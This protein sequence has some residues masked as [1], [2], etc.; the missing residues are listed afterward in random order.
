MFNNAPYPK[1][2]QG[3]ITWFWL[4]NQNSHMQFAT[5]PKLRGSTLNEDQV[6]K[7]RPPNP[8]KN[9]TNPRRQKCAWN[10]QQ[11]RGRAALVRQRPCP[12]CRVALTQRRTESSLARLLHH[13]SCRPQM[14]S[15][16]W[17]M[18]TATRCT[19][20]NNHLIWDAEKWYTTD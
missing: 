5:R 13:S 16:S 15:T 10:S 6:G 14:H 1:Y 7:E 11:H 17:L 4:S 19:K 18:E 20:N 9:P 2:S 3:I 8:C 12:G